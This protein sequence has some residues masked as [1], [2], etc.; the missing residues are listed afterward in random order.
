M[1]EEKKMEHP[2]FFVLYSKKY[3]KFVVVFFPGTLD[4]ALLTI[5]L[6]I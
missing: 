2:W 1:K 6:N 3:A 4:Q 5:D